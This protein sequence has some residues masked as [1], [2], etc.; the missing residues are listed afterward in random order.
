MSPDESVTYVSGPYL[1]RLTT[2]CSGRRSAAA[3]PERYT[4][5]NRS[6]ILFRLWNCN[7]LAL[8]HCNTVVV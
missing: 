2:G 8:I 5:R 4:A 6:T 3:E 7:S 1:G